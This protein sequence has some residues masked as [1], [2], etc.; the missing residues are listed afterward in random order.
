VCDA[1][2][3]TPFSRWFRGRFFDGDPHRFP[4]GRPGALE[5]QFVGADGRPL[6]GP[7]ARCVSGQIFRETSNGAVVLEGIYVPLEGAGRAST[8]PPASAV[9]SPLIRSEVSSIIAFAIGRSP[10]SQFSESSTVDG[11]LLPSV[12]TAPHREY[13]AH[14]LGFCRTD[15]KPI[16]RAR[17]GTSTDAKI[18]D[19][20]PSRIA[21]AM[22]DSS[23]SQF[24]ETTVDVQ[25]PVFEIFATD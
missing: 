6:W 24:S 23:V 25:S 14:V 17:S 22:V 7:E 15:R 11:R 8:S 16:H 18:P 5:G 12:L 21:F 4:A 20:P 9:D 1:V 10:V 13:S 19:T 3:S 2:K